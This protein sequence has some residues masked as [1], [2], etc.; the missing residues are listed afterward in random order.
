MPLINFILGVLFGAV[1]LVLVATLDNIIFKDKGFFII[2]KRWKRY[3]IA[4][5]WELI[6]FIM[7]F[8]MGYLN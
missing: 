6:F 2:T 3:L 4:S 7:G 1:L 8:I 5:C